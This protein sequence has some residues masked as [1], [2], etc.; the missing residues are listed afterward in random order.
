M[1]EF[2]GVRVTKGADGGEVREPV[3]PLEGIG[4]EP[5]SDDV[6]ESRVEVY[7]ARF[8]AEAAGSVKRS[9][10]YVQQAITPTRTKRAEQPETATEEAS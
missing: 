4:G 7:E 9:G 1:W 8:G 5:M 3:E 2:V 6:F 10:L